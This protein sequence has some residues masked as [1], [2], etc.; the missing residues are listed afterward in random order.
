MVRA[1]PEYRIINE[2]RKL[3]QVDT[4]Y[5]T[6]KLPTKTKEKKPLSG[7]FNAIHPSKEQQRALKK[8]KKTTTTKTTPP[9][10]KPTKR[11]RRKK[12]T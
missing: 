12:R 5:Q 7:V 11:Q 2:S 4:V 8:F 9:P 1:L 3:R 6:T 10:K